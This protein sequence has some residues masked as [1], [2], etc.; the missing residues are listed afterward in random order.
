V[1]N[2]VQ[3]TGLD[4]DWW[5]WNIATACGYQRL[6]HGRSGRFRL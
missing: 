2:S 6:C 5:S 1:S 4:L 3:T